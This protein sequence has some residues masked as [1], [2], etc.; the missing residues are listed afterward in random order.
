MN[1]NCKHKL[2]R[3]TG[4]TQARTG[5]ALPSSRGGPTGRRRAGPGKQRPDHTAVSRWAS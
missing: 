1:T 2:H 5:Q 4:V 3:L